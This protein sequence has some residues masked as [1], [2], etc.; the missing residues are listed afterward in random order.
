MHS[1]S[2]EDKWG[3]K[4]HIEKTDSWKK[5]SSEGSKCESKL[6]IRQQMLCTVHVF[7]CKTQ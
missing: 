2:V 1:F 6:G 4:C 3:K 5:N 7:E